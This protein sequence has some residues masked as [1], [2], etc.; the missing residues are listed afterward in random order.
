MKARKSRGTIVIILE[1]DLEK[2]K[3]FDEE[4]LSDNQKQVFSK[5]SA[6]ER[7]SIREGYAAS[8]VDLDSGETVCEFNMEGYRP[9]QSAIDRFAEALLP[10]IQEFLSKE[11]N[12]KAL[13]K[14]RAEQESKK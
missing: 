7:E 11:E 4:A 13:E 1:T 2:A 8:V 9:P 5:L 12:R 3:P 10:R 6:K 14:W